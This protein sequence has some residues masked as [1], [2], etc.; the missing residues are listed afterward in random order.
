LKAA[1]HIIAS[2][3]D[4]ICTFNTGFDS[5]NLHRP[6]KWIVLRAQNPGSGAQ[7]PP[8]VG[9]FGAKVSHDLGEFVVQRPAQLGLRAAHEQFDLLS[10]LS[11]AAAAVTGLV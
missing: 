3:A 1:Q 11:G 7:N 4:S 9:V 10:L 6:T 2:N 8:D 5:S